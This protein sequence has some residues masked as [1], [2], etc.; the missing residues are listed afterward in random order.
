M[1]RPASLLG[2]FAGIFEIMQS[3]GV[4]YEVAHER[5][6]QSQREQEQETN[7]VSLDDYRRRARPA[8]L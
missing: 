7:I 1:T 5:W 2:A 4:S 3:D 8:A 6:Q